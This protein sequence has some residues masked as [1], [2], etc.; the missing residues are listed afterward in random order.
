MRQLAGTKARHDSFQIA[1]VR[2]R[3]RQFL[4]IDAGN[5]ELR[6]EASQVCP[7]MIPGPERCDDIDDREALALEPTFVSENV[8]VLSRRRNLIV[9]QRGWKGTLVDTDYTP[10]GARTTPCGLRDFRRIIR[11]QQ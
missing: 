7:P 11:R 6:F 10:D 2:K 1:N 9:E 8:K 3:L 5:S 4:L